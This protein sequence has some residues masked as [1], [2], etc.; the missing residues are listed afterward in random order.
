MN[1]HE[2]WIHG[3][4]VASGEGLMAATVRIVGE[5]IAEVVP[6]TQTHPSDHQARPSNPVPLAGAPTVDAAGLWVLPGGVDAHVHFGMP[7]R[8]GIRSLD[9]RESSEA[10]LLGGT[11]TV[12]DFANPARD[13][14]LLAARDRWLSRATGECLCDF[15][16]HVTICEAKTP[17]L[18]EI[19]LL[20]QQGIPTFKAFLAYKNRLMLTPAELQRV[21]EA[22][23]GAGGRLLVHAEDGELN[24]AAEQRL[25]HTGRLGPEWH[26]GAHPPEAEL[27]AIRTTLDLARRTGCPVTIV[28]VSLADSVQLVRQARNANDAAG[29]PPDMSD[30]IAAEVC[31]HHM[32]A[33]SG[34]CQGSYEA[35][36]RAVLAPPIRETHDSAQLLAGLQAGDLDLLSTDHC[37]FPL[38][39][40]LHEARRGFPAIPNGAGGVGERLTIAYAKG[41]VTGQLSVARWIASCCEKPAVLVG[42]AGRKGRIAAG[43]DADLVLF[44]PVAEGTWLPLGSS[45]PASNLYRG[46]PT[47]GAVRSVWRRGI[48]VVQ[49]GRLRA[50]IE[51]GKFLARSFRRPAG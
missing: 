28:H 6:A 24:A 20:V 32:F 5:Q 47:R 44:D 21:M 27:L 45:D 48:L 37:E 40:K 51:P 33:S 22:V 8:D 26:P 17:R 13:E 43:Y 10:A 34:H 36:L 35:F 15:G 38:A 41:V 31:L 39:V 19:P 30:R 49:D 1:P 18:A 4:R 29:D 2:F 46:T 42:L 3:G 23:A 50:G 11:T 9:W 7:L 25:I 12:I 16:L 14:S